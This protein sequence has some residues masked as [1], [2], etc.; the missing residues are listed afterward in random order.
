M[1]VSKIQTGLRL[2]EELYEK[3]KTLSEMEGR[4]LNNLAEYVIRRFVAE[5]EEKNGPLPRSPN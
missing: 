3:F 2:E 1:A 4:S 5:Y